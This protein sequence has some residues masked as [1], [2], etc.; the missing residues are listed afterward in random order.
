MALIDDDDRLER[1]LK[2]LPSPRAPRTLL[3]RVM[4]AVERQA[5]QPHG[6]PWFM[7]RREWQ[8]VSVAAAMFLLAGLAVLLS[9]PEASVR[10]ATQLLA[11]MQPDVLPVVERAASLFGL[12][13]TLWR[14]VVEPV[15]H[16]LLI[17]IVVM[18]TACAAFVAALGRV[19][20]GEATQ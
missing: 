14:A 12:A 16:Y 13:G 3:P 1:A 2:A 11:R 19:A 8:V 4:T 9:G 15:L 6:R 18:S 10:F 17:W 7:W 5:P 20:F